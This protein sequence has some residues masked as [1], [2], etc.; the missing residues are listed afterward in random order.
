M[1]RGDIVPKGSKGSKELIPPPSSKNRGEANYNTP[2]V[3]AIALCLK[4]GKASE[5][6]MAREI[7][8]SRINT[9]CAWRLWGHV[10]EIQGLGAG[11]SDR[12]N[13]HFV[14]Q[15]KSEIATEYV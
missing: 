4:L 7:L 15:G 2:K 13:P 6:V 1:R 14:R 10:A 12:A 11:A 8:P 5:S 9:D 3:L